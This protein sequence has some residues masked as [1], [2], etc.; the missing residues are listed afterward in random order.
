MEH[1]PFVAPD[2]DPRAK[3]IQQARDEQKA[4][5]GAAVSLVPNW[6]ELKELVNWMADDDKWECSAIAEAVSEPERFW[7][8]MQIAKAQEAMNNG[9]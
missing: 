3:A 5:V 7:E 9:E 6:D 4:G 8:Y 1:N 2:T